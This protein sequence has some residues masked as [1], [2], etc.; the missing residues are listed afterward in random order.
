M[1][2]S[3]K[4]ALTDVDWARVRMFSTQ[5]NIVH[6]ITDEGPLLFEFSTAEEARDAIEKYFAGQAKRGG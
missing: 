4:V 6:I 1:S 3:K 5:D 2:D